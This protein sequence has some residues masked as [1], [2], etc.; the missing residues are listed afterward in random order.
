MHSLSNYHS[1]FLGNWM[2]TILLGIYHLSL[3]SSPIYLTCRFCNLD[4]LISE[5]FQHSSVLSYWCYILAE[6]LLTTILK[7]P[8]L[9]ILAH[10]QIL[11]VCKHLTLI[12][13]SGNFDCFEVV[14]IYLSYC[15]KCPWEQVEWNNPT[16]FAKAGEYD[17]SVSST[18]VF[19]NTNCELESHPFCSEYL[20]CSSWSW[21]GAEGKISMLPG[22]LYQ[23]SVSAIV[24]FPSHIR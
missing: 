12:Y 19:W 6:M 22:C 15:Q 23:S 1:V 11:T 18:L 9:I 7:G 21:N 10:V 8:S 16:C 3:G 24:S 17:K 4:L 13:Y 5:W 2:T 14:I 20:A